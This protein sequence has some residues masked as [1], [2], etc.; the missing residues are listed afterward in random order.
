MEIDHVREN[1]LGEFDA[2]PERKAT[3]TDKIEKRGDRKKAIKDSE[4]K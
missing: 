3:Q 4:H 2:E 1:K